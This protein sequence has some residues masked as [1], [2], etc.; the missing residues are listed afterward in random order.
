MIRDRALVRR[1]FAW[2]IRRAGVK[3]TR[4]S[5]SVFRLDGDAGIA[6]WMPGAAFGYS[7]RRVVFAAARV[8]TGVMTCEG[9]GWNAAAR[10]ISK[11]GV[12]GGGNRWIIVSGAWWGNP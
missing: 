2:M 8:S 4:L 5:L 12:S 1:W 9:F 3:G 7:G 6:R 11:F 10:R